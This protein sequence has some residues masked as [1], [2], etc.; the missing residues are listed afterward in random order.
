MIDL[1]QS[2]KAGDK[3]AFNQLYSQLYT[4]LYRFVMSRTHNQEKT[5]DIC[6]ETFIKWY[7]SL[8][9]YEVKIKPL[10]YLMMISMRLII[11]DSKKKTTVEL[12]EN[13]EEY[14]PDESESI[15]EL[16]DFKGEIDK[17]QQLFEY[18]N[19]D[20]KNVLS[21]RYIADAD[22]ETIAEALD[23]TIV[24]IRQIESRALK[25]IRELYKEIHGGLHI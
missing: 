1:I 15:E 16:L 13:A 17:I 24:N 5:L 14:I 18:L 22:T 6:Q 25:K 23:K 7:Q 3:N 12:P 19:E 21:M 20:Q 11:N 9:T 4:P 10:S 2:A 8:E